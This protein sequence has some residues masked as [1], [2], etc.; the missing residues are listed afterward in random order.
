MSN[1]NLPPICETAVEQ[2]IEVGNS[3]IPATLV[4]KDIYVIHTKSGKQLLKGISGEIS[5]GF[6]AIM[7]PSGGG[8]T[9]FL[10]SLSRRLS[11]STQLNGEIALNGKP[12]KSRQLKA[13][14]AYVMQDD[15]L[16]AYFTVEDT[17]MFTSRLRMPRGTPF[18]LI[19]ERVESV[20]FN[21]ELERARNTIVGNS[22]M[23]GISGGEKKRLCIAMELITQPSLLFLDE[24]TSGLD[25]LTALNICQRLRKIGK[26]EN[27]TIITTIHQPQTKLFK[28][29]DSLILLRDGYIVYQGKSL[30]SLDYFKEKGFPLPPM[31]NPADHL[32][33]I[34]TPVGKDYVEEDPPIGF[35]NLESES[36][37]RRG[38]SKSAR[39][40]PENYDEMS[41]P[42]V[43]LIKGIERIFPLEKDKIPW[44]SQFRILVERDFLEYRR[45]WRK[46]AIKVGVTIFMA[47]LI[48]LVFYQIGNT[49]VS[50]AKRNSALFFCCINQG[51]FTAFE[52]LNQFPSER[53]LTLRE[54]KAGTYY[55]S[56][57]YLS[58]VMFEMILQ[59]IYP[60]IF[61]VIVYFFIG[62]QDDGSKFIIFLV[63]VILC[64]MSSKSLTIMITTLCR[65]A[66]MSVVYLPLGLEMTRLFGGFFLPPVFLP[67]YFSWLDSLSYTK[68]AYTGVG[69]NEFQGLKLV[70][71]EKE[72]KGGDCPY[73]DGEQ[74]ID[75]LGLNYIT[76]NEAVFILIAYI[77]ITRLIAYL[78]IRYLKH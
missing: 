57:Y 25:S 29:F 42:K 63:F 35:N 37:Y 76:K 12:Y 28:L 68:Y 73:T 60:F 39:Y 34:I 70:C 59:I 49:Q 33:D 72:L 67:K 2:L 5:G 77:I 32:I 61:S 26:A 17:L 36:D 22:I 9:T 64:S 18:A 1:N 20:I 75:Y 74:Y 47:C 56:A 15:V 78:G 58:K 44:R 48:G 65:T 51:I 31:T 52:T 50:I 41:K 13:M 14:S 62:F 6:C 53:T 45:K 21:M 46:L 19:K 24:P 30:Y 8:K 23:H 3:A 55:V 16:N 40:V 11:K 54:R 38:F 7:G 71:L 66:D 10:N 43:N 69:L 27:Q 4:W